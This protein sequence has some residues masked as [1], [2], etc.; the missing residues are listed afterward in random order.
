MTD[1]TSNIN[2]KHFCSPFAVSDDG[3]VLL[4][5]MIDV[6]TFST[7]S[8]MFI[9]LSNRNKNSVALISERK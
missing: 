7:S 8:L 4:H 5:L 1:S 2:E 6:R 3:T 9:A